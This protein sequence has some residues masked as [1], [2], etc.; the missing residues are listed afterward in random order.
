MRI[1][2]LELRQGGEEVGA[3]L[4][5]QRR[6]AGDD[7]LDVQPR[8]TLGKGRDACVSWVLAAL[9]RNDQT[10]RPERLS[11]QRAEQIFEPGKRTRRRQHQGDSG[12]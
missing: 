9:D 5:A 10:A 12:S 6:Q 8:I 4:A 11:A 7:Q 1:I 2:C 3:F